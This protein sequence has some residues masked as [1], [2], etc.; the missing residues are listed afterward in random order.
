MS[1]KMN[2]PL[3]KAPLLLSFIEQVIKFDGKISIQC[4]LANILFITGR[5]K[6]KQKD[7]AT[8]YLK[9]NSEWNEDILNQ[10]VLID[11]NKGIIILHFEENGYME[12]ES[13]CY[14]FSPYRHELERIFS[15]DFTLPSK[16][17]KGALKRYFK[18]LKTGNMEIIVLDE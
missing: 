16:K 3:S 13:L 4:D 10:S 15:N 9:K 14:N 12:V 1:Q 11:T 8:V 17:E 5:C 7:C 18:H 2:I 6:C